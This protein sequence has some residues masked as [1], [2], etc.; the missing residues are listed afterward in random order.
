MTIPKHPPYKQPHPTGAVLIWRFLSGQH[1]KGRP[2]NSTF[3]YRATRDLTDHQHASKWAHRAGWERSLI[4]IPVALVI[5]A[6]IGGGIY[7]QFVNPRLTDLALIMAGSLAFLGFMWWV[8]A[9]ATSHRHTQRVVRPI[10]EIAASITG[11][12]SRHGNAAGAN[13]HAYVKVPRNWRHPAAVVTV[14][15]PPSWEGRPEDLR[16]LKELIERRLGGDW[17][18]RYRVDTW[19]QRVEFRPAPAPPA[20]LKWAEV[21]AEIAKLPAGQL[22]IGHGT[23]GQAVTIDLDSES[24]HIALS[25]GTGGGKS[26]TLRSL[27]VQLLAQGVERVDIIDMKRVSHNWARDLPGVYIH[28]S[29]EESIVAV[30][31]FRQRM[32]DRYNALDRD[33]T[34]TFPRQVLL[35]EEQNSWTQYAKSYWEDYRAGL[36]KEE[37]QRTPRACPAIAD[38]AYCLFQGRQ[39]RMNVISVFQRMSAAA[40]GGG[41]LRENYGAFVLAR[42]SRKTWMMLVGTTPVPRSSRIPGR[43]RVVIGDLDREV[44]MILITEAEARA[45]ALKLAKIPAQGGAAPADLGDMPGGG[46]PAPWPARKPNEKGVNDN[47]SSG[48]QNP[49]NGSDR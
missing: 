33:E 21:A 13:P 27:V 19:P 47:E 20:A 40:A 2:T 42:F 44:Q 14:Q 23:R 41:D 43:A 7:G 11:G 39:A 31:G 15:T 45:A 1:M 12:T 16:R 29:I 3:L 6:V 25:M 24:P 28:R 17:D 37:K 9:S 8:Y 22:M 48:L 30:A 36:D 38:L 35:V 18:A 4:R 10:H 49:R 46:G 5:I 32:E 26:A 34:A